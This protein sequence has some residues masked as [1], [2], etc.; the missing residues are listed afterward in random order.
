MRIKIQNDYKDC[1]LCVVES[2]YNHF[3]GK[4]LEIENIKKTS[5][6]T[7]RGLNIQS[8][9]DLGN[10][11]GVVLDAFNA[12]FEAINQNEGEVMVAVIESQG[13]GHYV[14][15]KKQKDK[16]LILDPAKGKYFLSIEEFK[17]LYQGMVLTVLKG[18]YKQEIKE[19]TKLY[20]IIL[21]SMPIFIWIIISILIGIIFSFVSTLFMKTTLDYILPGHLSKTFTLL[22]IGFGFMA[23]LRVL[24]L[25]LRKYLV[26]K[27]EL[28]I[29]FEIINMFLT[30]M[31]NA[32]LHELN[33]YSR[34]DILRRISLI[35]HISAFISSGIFLVVN[36][37]IVFTISMALL[38][39]ISPTLFALTL[40]AG[41]I[42]VFIS[43]TFNF[44]I[45]S[46]YEE[47]LNKQMHVMEKRWDMISS[48]KDLK[49][50]KVAFYLKNNADNSYFEYRKKETRIWNTISI[51]TLF[52]EMIHFVMPI[53][54]TY[55]SVNM[56]FDRKLTL[57][58]MMMFLGVFST[59][60]S[61]LL[62]LCDFF[63]K[64]KQNIKN[65]KLVESFVNL[66]DE[67]D[68][69][70]GIV[71]NKIENICL[72]NYSYKLDKDILNIRSLLI[73]ENIILSGRNGSGKSS[74]LK[75]LAF[76]N[77][78]NGILVNGIEA[79]YYSLSPLRNKVF[80]TSPESELVSETIFDQVTL[81][82]S[83]AKRAFEIN[84]SKCNLKHVLDKMNINLNLK[85]INGGDNLSSGQ[86]QLVK[87]LRLFAFEY[88]FVLLDE[89]F[90]NIDN[91]TFAFL[92]ETLPKVQNAI[93]VEVS[94]SKRY[95]FESKEVNIEEINFC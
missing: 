85:I 63:V 72:S 66:K 20:K 6:I 76:R 40:S 12:P 74:L 88:D 70:K 16:Y 26:R 23:F 60:I 7:E 79:E 25:T 8:L 89:A 33:K 10:E 78:S 68:N 46:E 1:G 47:I 32:S 91:E 35:E 50:N 49:E 75:S 4:N 62:Q 92:K 56:I 5:Q 45:S 93:F 24:N 48:I 61:P 59:F 55:V 83:K 80:I 18:N 41:L 2:L 54:M 73:N 11:Y 13:M 30:K 90:E 52:L 82:D 9:I 44:F 28:S 3:W 29:E 37:A 77:N 71:V 42:S 21:N 51:Q 22:S 65:Y 87:L 86:R 57:G 34:N 39:W 53:V 15:F 58:T 84:V 36:E 94:H 69:P 64:L 14:I 38:I 31:Q 19:D 27:I 17:S 95:V 81:N 67:A 43:V